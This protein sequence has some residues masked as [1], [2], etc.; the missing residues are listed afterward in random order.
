[1]AQNASPPAFE[2]ASVKPNTSGTVQR[3]G[4]P[5]PGPLSC[6]SNVTLR[7]LIQMAYS[8]Q[9]FDRR[10]IS[11]GPDWIDSGRFDVEAKI[12][13]GQAGISEDCICRIARALLDSRTRW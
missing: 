2:V 4:G 8:Q 11:G 5:Q 6:D 3:C 7:Q 1:M 12:D 10:E 9:A 13:D